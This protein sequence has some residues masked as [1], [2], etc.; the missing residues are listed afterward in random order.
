MKRRVALIVIAL[1][2]SLLIAIPDAHACSCMASDPRDDLHAADGAFAGTYVGREPVDLTDPYADWDY[3]FETETVYKGDIGETIAVRAPSNGA[4][5]GLEYSEGS[6]AALFVYLEEGVWHSEL[7]RTVPQEIL[8]IAAAPFPEPNAQGPPVALVGGSFGEVRVIAVDAQGRT[9]GYGYGDGDALLMSMCPGG[10]RSIEMVGAYLTQEERFVDVRS[11]SDLEVV[12]TTAAPGNWVDEFAFPIDVSCTDEQGS[13]VV[14]SRGY[15]DDANY[16]E[17]T[18]FEDGSAESILRSTAKH[19]AVG[20]QYAFL[21]ARKKVSKVD[22]CSGGRSL[23]RSFGQRASHLTLSPDNS[24]LAL[25]VGARTDAGK[26]LVVR[27][28]NGKV[29]ARRELSSQASFAKLEWADDNS[30][31]FWGLT[32]TSPL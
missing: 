29:T 13:A 32:Q 23:L 12:A 26:L 1:V 28:D 5:C 25:I 7:C 3:H 2:G 14:F 8:E 15:V 19:G 27:T 11:I 4:G 16:T 10:Q 22:L 31:L 24:R 18:R 9:A 20:R 6:P 30:L 17:L 21:G